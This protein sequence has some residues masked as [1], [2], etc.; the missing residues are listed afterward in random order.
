MAISP[1]FRDDKPLGN[2]PTAMPIPFQQTAAFIVE[3]NG[4]NVKVEFHFTV[5]LFERPSKIS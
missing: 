5:I 2:L 1:F 3:K 4:C